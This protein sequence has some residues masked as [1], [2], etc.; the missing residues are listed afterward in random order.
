MSKRTPLSMMQK[1]LIGG[2]TLLVA[3]ALLWWAW[4]GWRPSPSDY[5]RQGVEVNAMSGTINWPSVRAAG[6]D[7][8]YVEASFGDTDRNTAFAAQWEESA[9][10]GL[11]RGA[12]HRFHICRLARDQATNFI[13]MV[14]READEL[15]PALDL[16]LDAGCTAHP[17]RSVLLAEVASFIQMVEAHVEKPVI[18]RVSPR[19]EA[20]F[21]ISRAID[22]PLWLSSRVFT[23]SYGERPWVMW[24]ANPA[25]PVNG[26]EKPV[27]WSVVRP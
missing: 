3:A 5:P 18:I 2:A 6:A 10:A 12:V 24:Q 17:A 19:F 8:A 11:T 4:Q 7:F 13:A 1:G 14:P 27:G 21:S 16:D 22:R 25:R 23:P 26:I 9:A 15:P 20:E